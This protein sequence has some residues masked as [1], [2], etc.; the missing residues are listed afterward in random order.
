TTHSPGR[1]LDHL[2]SRLELELHILAGLDPLRELPAPGLEGVDP[3]FEGA[4]VP[5][6]L[7]ARELRTPAVVDQRRHGGLRPIA[8][9]LVSAAEDCR[10]SVVAV[11]GDVRL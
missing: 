3:A 1:G 9:R 11:G 6:E 7:R 10:Q 5:A 8:A 4:L 2:G